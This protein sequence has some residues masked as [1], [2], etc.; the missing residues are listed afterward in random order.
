MA[1]PMRR[2]SEPALQ[3]RRDEGIAAQ[4]VATNELS[5]EQSDG[6]L[7]EAAATDSKDDRAGIAS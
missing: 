6:D 3:C 2:T 5:R 7:K 1:C 4:A